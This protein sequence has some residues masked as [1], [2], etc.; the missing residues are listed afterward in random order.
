MKDYAI[1]PEHINVTHHFWD[2]FGNRETEISANWLVHFAQQ[3]GQGWAPFSEP[4]IQKFYWGNSSNHS[5]RFNALTVT[6]L[7]HKPITQDAA[8]LYHFTHEFVSR[9]FIASPA[10]SHVEEPEEVTA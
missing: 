1:Q 2:A 5:F 4:D 8:G 9:C 7:T 6:P 3:R 10:C